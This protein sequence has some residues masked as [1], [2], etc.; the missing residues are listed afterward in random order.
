MSKVLIIGGG[1]AGMM[2]GIFAGRNG[3]EVHIYEKN[4]KLGKKLFITG[5]GRCNITNA[6]DMDT[7]FASVTTNPKFLY[8]GF[9]S[10]TNEQAVEFFEELGV[11]TKVE[12]GNRV[13]PVS[14]HSSDVISAMSRELQRVHAAVH[15]NSGVKEIR[16]REGRFH[17]LLLLNGEEIRGDACIVATGGVS[18]PS[19]GSTGDGY[20]FARESGHRV[21]EL[22]PSLVPIE[23]QEEDV[24]ELQGLSLRNVNACI[25]QGKK[26]VYEEFGEMLFTHY[27]VSGPIIISASSIIGKK[28]KEGGLR[29][30]IDLKPALSFEQLDAR[31]LRDFEENRNK[32]FKN[33]VDKL[34]PAKLKP[35][36][37]ARSGIDP[38]KK[39]NEISRE[40]RHR[41]VTEIKNFEMTLVK[42]RDFKE[43]IITKGGV[44]VKQIDP[45]TME[46]KLVEGLYFIGEVL[47][48]DALTGGFNL[49]IA[50]STAYLAGISIQ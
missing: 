7:L 42:L 17:S 27:G 37:I 20:R 10:F 46:S 47:D 36:M 50:W 30:V 40:E 24:K 43:A 45:G 41:F 6:G 13:F 35:V 15:L 5:K 49:Q 3:H 12:R 39:V 48:L 18:Y 9:Y 14:D 1:A 38:E 29:L 16:T 32:Q 44:D 21:T 25:Y 2:A 28:L 23:T 34:F 19:T 4:E 8:S 31:V 11:R 33:A 26:K 22:S